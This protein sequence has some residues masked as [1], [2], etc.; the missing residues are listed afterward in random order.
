VNCWKFAGRLLD[1]VNTPQ[2]VLQEGQT[3]LRRVA[4]V[5][6]RELW[7]LL[8]TFPFSGFNYCFGVYTLFFL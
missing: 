6:G 1:R 8:W 4:V 3:S 7:T 5:C 2:G